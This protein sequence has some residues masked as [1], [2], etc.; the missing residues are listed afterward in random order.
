MIRDADIAK[1]MQNFTRA[2]ILF[3]SGISMLSQV[4]CEASSDNS[5]HSRENPKG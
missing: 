4:V 2:Q 3:N 5:H 1:E